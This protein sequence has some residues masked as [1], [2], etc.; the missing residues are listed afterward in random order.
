MQTNV[1]YFDS[2]L[3]EDATEDACAFAFCKIGFIVVFVGYPD[4]VDT[5][6]AFLDALPSISLMFSAVTYPISIESARAL[7][8][9]LANSWLTAVTSTSRS[10]ALYMRLL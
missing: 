8:Y 5:A 7:A 6:T 10:S 9:E 1:S 2:Y 4:S 3:E